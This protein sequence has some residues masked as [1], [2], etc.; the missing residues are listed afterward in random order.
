MANNDNSA[1]LQ[2]LITQRDELVKQYVTLDPEGR[3]EFVF[4]AHTD[5]VHGG[6][7]SRVQY[8]Y[9]NPTTTLI[10]KMIES[11]DSWDSSYDI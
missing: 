3:I 2:A 4:T 5:Q 11:N 10:Q 6:S 1:R 7:C 8:E 9:F